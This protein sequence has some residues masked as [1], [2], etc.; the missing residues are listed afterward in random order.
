MQ[1]PVNS[2]STNPRDR[3]IALASETMAE[4][5]SFWG[6]KNSMGR[7]WTLLYLTPHAL[8]ADVIADRTGLSAGSVSMALAELAEWELVARDDP[9]G[10]TKRHYRAETEVWTIVRRIFR[11]R[12]LVL[13]GRAVD[14]F[15]EAIAI[16]ERAQGDDPKDPE[17]ALLLSRLR[18]LHG[19]AEMGYGLVKRFADIGQ[20]TLAPLR[21]LLSGRATDA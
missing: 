4:L 8:P 20:F 18:G 9:P 3:A 19:L 10:A 12:E 13:V 2:P 7:I 6:F 5:V 14:R 17:L 11:E 16:V 15:A 1:S 21:G